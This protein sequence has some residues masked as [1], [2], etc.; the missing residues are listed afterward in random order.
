MMAN[1]VPVGTPLR[2]SRC[3]AIAYHTDARFCSHCGA[4]LDAD[5]SALPHWQQPAPARYSHIV[6]SRMALS[7]PECGYAMRFG[8][9]RVC[10]QCGAK[11][12][13]VPRLLHPNHYRVYVCGPRAA[14]AGL[15]VEL[16]WLAA[17]VGALALIGGA[18][19]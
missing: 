15:T 13:M 3:G 6:M 11:L 14:L 10:R 9:R 4:A 7:C 8:F 2:C 12:V 16:F 19:K 18:L 5:E 1:A 17:I